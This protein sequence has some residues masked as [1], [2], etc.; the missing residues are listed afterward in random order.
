MCQP[1]SWL[2][3]VT[4]WSLPGNLTVTR[5]IVL[6]SGFTGAGKQMLHLWFD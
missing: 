6:I 2:G 3:A 4:S 5:Y 1:V